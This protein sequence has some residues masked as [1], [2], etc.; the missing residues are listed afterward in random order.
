[1]ILTLT[2]GKVTNFKVKFHGKTTVSV[3]GNLLNQSAKDNT[4]NSQI[5]A[6]IQIFDVKT[7]VSTQTIDPKIITLYQ[8]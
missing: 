8:L 6:V 4:K 2:N 1:M 7:D 5:G 3:I